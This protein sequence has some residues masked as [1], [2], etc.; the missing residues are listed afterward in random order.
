MDVKSNSTHN[1]RLVDLA[2][3]SAGVRVFGFRLPSADS[4]YKIHSFR[5]REDWAARQKEGTMGWNDRDFDS[6][7]PVNQPVDDDPYDGNY[8]GYRAPNYQR[9]VKSA[10][11]NTSPSRPAPKT[12]NPVRSAAPKASPSSSAPSNISPQPYSSPPSQQ[13]GGCGCLV[14]IG[15][16]AG[17]LAGGLLVRALMLA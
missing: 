11:R 1:P 2:R 13:Q 7:D 3:S 9:P 14:L 10:P 12:D 4:R 16:G 15:V 17:L 6:D 5:A 8:G